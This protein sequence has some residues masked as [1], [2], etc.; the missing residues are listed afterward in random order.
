[1]ANDMQDAGIQLPDD[2]SAAGLSR[3]C[4]KRP[5]GILPL[6]DLLGGPLNGTEQR[7]APRQLHVRG[8][9]EIPLP[10][11][12]VS[13]VGTRRPTEEG[14]AEARAVSGML[15]DNGIVVVSGL[16]AGIDA[17][18][19][20]AAIEAGGRTVA[21]LGTPLD[22]TY[23]ASHYHLQKYIADNHLVV[24]QFPEGHPVVK[25]NFVKRNRTM[26]LISDAS[27]MVEAGEG[28]GT[29]NHGWEA[30]RLGRPL[31]VCGLAARPGH[32][33]LAEMVRRGA[34]ILEDH[35]Q[36]LDK[37]PQNAKMHCVSVTDGG[38]RKC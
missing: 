14:L 2:R 16:A 15:A 23:P 13:V 34:I 29:I 17:T 31:F 21:V 25:G 32:K 20:K 33:W 10:P 37:I 11:S 27:V 26:A 30:L 6:E 7:N 24:S 3:T 19:H 12:R 22:K 28:S 8:P 9:M 18:A 38:A 5:A 4:H 36:I 1:M 35:H